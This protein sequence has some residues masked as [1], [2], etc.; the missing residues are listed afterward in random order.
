MFF[1]AVVLAA[2]THVA[3]HFFNDFGG[4]WTCGNSQYHAQW[5]ITSPEGNYWTIVQYGVDLQHPGGTAY[6]GFLPQKNAY[7]YND[8][9]ADGSLAQL[10]S[11]LPGAD[12]TWRWTGVFYQTGKD[13]DPNGDI[14][15]TLTP[16]GTIERHFRKVVNGTP[17]EMGS[18]TCTKR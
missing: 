14:T 8:F 1:S 2:T 7:V 11:P 6:V 16:K 5:S 18:D 13:P 10:S 15:W 4:S 3:A 12:H 9:H 17:K